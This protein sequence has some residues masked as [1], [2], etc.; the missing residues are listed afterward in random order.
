MV[1]VLGYMCILLVTG[2]DHQESDYVGY[3]VSGA[4]LLV[5]AHYMSKKKT[6]KNRS[7]K[8]YT[9]NMWFF[10]RGT[11]REQVGSVFD[12]TVLI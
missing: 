3:D 8:T 6:L 5:T 12:I 10:V 1:F 11:W 4:Y 2:I 7:R 9:R